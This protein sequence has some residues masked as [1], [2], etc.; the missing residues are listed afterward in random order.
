MA[1]QKSTPFQWTKIPDSKEIKLEI[2]IQNYFLLSELLLTPCHNLKMAIKANKVEIIAHDSE[3]EKL[4]I[5][6]KI[7]KF[8]T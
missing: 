5:E 7:L 6:R 3:E 4:T 8:N 1:Q 2:E